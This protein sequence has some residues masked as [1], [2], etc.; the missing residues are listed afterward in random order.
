MAWDDGLSPDQRTAASH[1]DGHARLL[2]GPGTG[3]TKTLT[4]RVL[5][6]IEERGVEPGRIVGLTFTR[7]AAFELRERI[8]RELAGKYAERPTVATL[9][10][11]ALRNLLHNAERLDA[12]P[13]PLRIADD[14]EERNIILED[15]KR[16]MDGDVSI[17][18]VRDRFKD[19][20][21]DWNTLGIEGDPAQYRADANF[22]GAW[23]E[24]RGIYGY[25][26]RDELVYELKRALQRRADV[27]LVP[28]TDQLL[29]DEYQ[30]LNACDA[31]VIDAIRQR[32]AKVYGAGDDDQSIYGFRHALPIGIRTFLEKYAP[33]EDLKLEVCHRC[34]KAI[35]DLARFVAQLDIHSIPKP[36]TPRDGA[37][38]G[39]VLLLRFGDQFEEADGV[40]SICRNLID[41]A[42]HQPDDILMLLRNDWRSAFSKPL[43]AALNAAGVPCKLK[44][45]DE[46]PLDTD[47][48]R[49]ALSFLRLCRFKY[50]SLAWRTLLMVS[51]QGMGD[52]AFRALYDAARA[53]G[54]TVGQLL[55]EKDLTSIPTFGTRLQAARTAIL[56][57]L[58]PACA[59]F[60]APTDGTPAPPLFDRVSAVFNA[61]VRAADE[62]AAMLAYVQTV[63]TE[64]DATT[65]AE[66]LQAL[67]AAGSETEQAIV[68]GA[69]NILTMHRAKGLTARTVIVVGAE[70]EYIPGRQEG[71]PGEDDERRLLYVSLSRARER[72][73]ITYT[74]K[75]TGQQRHTGRTSGARVR[76]LT[77]YLQD[78][79]IGPVNGNDYVQT[80][81]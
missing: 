73:V 3:K 38:N 60:E 45:N 24:H 31:A 46:T 23:R 56:K 8:N 48:G 39:E 19:L 2:A 74:D 26:L 35:I 11:Y 53:A 76:N 40:A 9:H 18:D 34:D 47:A 71:T 28:P 6:L 15:L 21:A 43:V 64:A 57:D 58:V 1:A 55:T 81:G 62:R 59:L 61:V 79:P 50:D 44:V 4:G 13:Q 78:A 65:L 5:F 32:G 75:R 67:S 22:V 66:L 16:L 30:D 36:L 49:T 54:T 10:S 29:V 77:R 25:T 63:I 68:P 14:W 51:H 69:V 42:G 20:S 17:D 80:L 12:L 72:L 33:A 52:G 37:G 7:A 27:E 70:D 41:N